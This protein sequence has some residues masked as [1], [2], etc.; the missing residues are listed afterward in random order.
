M[1]KAK[2]GGS[3]GEYMDAM[4]LA[5]GAWSKDIGAWGKGRPESQM[6]T[7][8]SVVQDRAVGFAKQNAESCFAVASEL[9]K[10]KDIMEMM[11]LQTKVK[12][13]ARSYSRR[14]LTP[15][16]RKIKATIRRTGAT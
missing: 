9:A 6:T 7:G 14:I 12:T 11:S 3:G 5:L 4:T 8:F 16:L 2:A 1:A 15:A 13:T 10:A